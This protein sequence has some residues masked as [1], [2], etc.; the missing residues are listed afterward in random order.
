LLDDPSRM[1]EMRRSAAQMA[2]PDAAAQIAE[3]ALR[4]LH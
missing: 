4:L 2:R 1:K 3:D